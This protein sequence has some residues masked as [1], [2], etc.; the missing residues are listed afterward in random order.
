[1]DEIQIVLHQIS[2]ERIQRQL[3]IAH[4]QDKGVVDKLVPHRGNVWSVEK[5][6]EEAT[7]IYAIF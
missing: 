5:I 2:L 3:A 4:G 6:L 1:M 7:P